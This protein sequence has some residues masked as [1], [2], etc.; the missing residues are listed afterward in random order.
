MFGKRVTLFKLFGFRVRIDISWL[1]IV[2]LISWTLAQSLFPHY[3]KDLSTQTYIIMGILGA[4][5]L[6]IS[7]I[8]H[9]MSHSLIARKFGLPITGI[10][11]FIFGGVAEMKEEPESAKAEFFMAIAGPLASISI[12]IILLGIYLLTVNSGISKIFIGV[13]HY[14]W[15]INFILAGFNL[16]P[17]FPLDGGR[18]L[19]SILWAWKGK[20]GWATRVASAF[21]S[22]FGFFLIFLGV[23]SFLMGN[24]VGGLWWFLI[25]LFIRNASKLSYRRVLIKNL[26]Q[27]EKVRDFMTKNVVT[28]SSAISIKELV[29]NYIY[30][31]HFKLFPVVDNGELKGCITTKNV[32]KVPRDQWSEKTVKQIIESCSEPETIHPDKDTMDALSLIRKSDNSRL[33]VVNNGNLVGIIALKDIMKYISDKLEFEKEK[34]E[35]M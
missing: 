16:I 6:F 28:V 7:I 21:G 9:E 15:M 8:L 24:L 14:L 22:S 13:V 34:Y 5:G 29:E 11:L 26:L 19:R 2:T 31:Y 4:L 32:K 23:I 1:I 25:G 20:L 30:Q 18:V 3:Y 35:N 17:A 33:M 27:G 10:T 12:G